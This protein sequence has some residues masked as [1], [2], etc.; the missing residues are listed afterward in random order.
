MN[1]DIDKQRLF[2]RFLRTAARDAVKRAK[3]LME[4]EEDD[5][6]EGD[7]FDEPDDDEG[8]TQGKPKGRQDKPTK[9]KGEG[10]VEDEDEGEDEV[11]DDI[12]IDDTGD[13]FDDETTNTDRK[14]GPRQ[15][16]AALRN[17]PPPDIDDLTY[18]M[19]ASKLNAIRSGSSLKDKETASR[20]A[21][22]I[23]SLNKSERLG[24]YAF[25][26]GLA[27]V[28]AGNVSGKKARQPDDPDINVA[29]TRVQNAVGGDTE[30]SDSGEDIS[31]MDDLFVTRG[32]N[33]HI[34]TQDISQT[35][36]QNIAP[37]V[38]STDDAPIMVVGR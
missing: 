21:N 25:L 32:D 37:V 16:K 33:M 31:T 35:T 24:L 29:I 22:Y 11:D 12:D 13:I 18:D 5:E 10:D 26:E 36:N 23:N 17:V 20:F 27:E 7:I 1:V 15:A 6:P 19:F 38:D 14:G 9:A 34:R 3:L 30:T 4:A 28:I 8:E 2:E